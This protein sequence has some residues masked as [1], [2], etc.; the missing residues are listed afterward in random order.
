MFFQ[1]LDEG[2]GPHPNTTPITWMPE[3]VMTL[4]PTTFLT[5][6]REGVLTPGPSPFTLMREGLP[7]HLTWIWE[8]IMTPWTILSSFTWIREG[9]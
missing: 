8:K 9:S 4:G 1:D 6:I 7:T 2:G 3:R 5:W